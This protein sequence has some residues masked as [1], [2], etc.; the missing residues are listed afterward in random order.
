LR[1][2]GGNADFSRPFLLHNQ[3]NYPAVVLLASCTFARK[4]GID[5]RLVI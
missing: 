2:N 5:A 1:R 4:S 3:G